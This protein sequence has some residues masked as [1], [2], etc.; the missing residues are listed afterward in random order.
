[1]PPNCPRSPFYTVITVM[2]PVITPMMNPM[3]IWRSVCCLRIMRALP[4]IPAKKIITE[5]HHIG[6]NMNIAA[7]DASE[8]AMAPI[9]AMWTEIFHHMFIM[10]HTTCVASAATTMLPMRCGMCISIMT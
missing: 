10:A 1:M 6:L 2:A 7:N 9:A 5:S 4:I 8:P 3:Y